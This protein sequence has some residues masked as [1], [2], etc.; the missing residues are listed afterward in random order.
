MASRIRK[1]QV[2]HVGTTRWVHVGTIQ[3][4]VCRHGKVV[5]PAGT[6]G[7]AIAYRCAPWTF[8][9]E[10]GEIQRGNLYKVRGRVY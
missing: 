1:G 4:D 7:V 9:N 5:I 10:N 6:R 8:E 3:Y 2:Y